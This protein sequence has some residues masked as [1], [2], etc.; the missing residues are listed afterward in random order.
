MVVTKAQINKRVKE[1]G[2]DVRTREYMR[3]L[4]HCA[5]ANIDASQKLSSA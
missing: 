5:L 1:N 3:K 2:K 4:Q